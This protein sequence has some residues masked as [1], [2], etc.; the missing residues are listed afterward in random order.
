MAR[1]ATLAG[2]EGVA[3]RHGGSKRGRVVTWAGQHEQGSRRYEE[4]ET[5]EWA[6]I[7]G[8]GR[9]TTWSSSLSGWTDSPAWIASQETAGEN[10]EVV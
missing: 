1:W 6:R 10:G 7:A 5:W 4:H 2:K 3:A 8:T 9:E